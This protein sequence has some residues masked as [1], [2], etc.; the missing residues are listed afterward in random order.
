MLQERGVVV[1]EEEDYCED[2]CEFRKCFMKKREPA[3]TEGVNA[4][5]ESSCLSSTLW[6]RSLLAPRKDTGQ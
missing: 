1:V 4:G 6:L 2:L 5:R 3:S